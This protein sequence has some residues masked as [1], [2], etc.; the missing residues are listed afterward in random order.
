MRGEWVYNA[1]FYNK[2]QCDYIIEKALAIE[3]EATKLGYS[4]EVADDSYRKSVVRW[5]HPNNEDLKFLFDDYW[6]FLISINK[7]WY[8]FN[9]THLPYLQFTEYDESYQ[10]EYKSHQDVFWINDS[11]Y[12]RKITG[13]IQLSGETSYDGG[14]LCLENC[15]ELPPEIIRNIGTMITFPSFV[16]H[17]LTP[18]T[19]GKRYS[20]VGWFEGPK[21]T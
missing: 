11:P 15:S 5:I 16:Q 8:G 18:I 13:I 9:V 17:R 20:L 1:G 7:E 21:F 12:H 6:K 14:D 2:E 3:P 10:G 19:K 4:G